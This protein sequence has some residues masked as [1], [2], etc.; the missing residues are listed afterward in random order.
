MLP[1]FDGRRKYNGCLHDISELDEIFHYDP[2]CGGLWYST[3]PKEH[4]ES[5]EDWRQWD[6]DFADHWIGGREW[7]N[8]RFPLWVHF[9][10]KGTLRNCMTYEIIL[11]LTADF[12][13]HHPYDI[14]YRDG[15]ALNT[16]LLN[17][18][19][20]VH[21]EEGSGYGFKTME[22][23]GGMLCYS[24]EFPSV[25]GPKTKTWACLEVA[26]NGDTRGAG[27]IPPL[28]SSFSA[29]LSNMRTP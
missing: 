21:G 14:S 13:V 27:L 2:Q 1:Q 4:F 25:L 10:Y 12:S 24:G 7:M 28:E 8:S 11:M 23:A 26:K 19:I 9:Y 20:T 29:I 16:D 6:D 3:R 18:K 5:E 15:D 17:M 22:K